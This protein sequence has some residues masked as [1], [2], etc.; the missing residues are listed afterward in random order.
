MITRE[1]AGAL[2]R[3]K[4]SDRKVAHVF[5]KHFKQDVEELIISQSAIRQAQIKHREAFAAEIKVAFKP[6]ILHW[7][8]KIMENAQVLE[9]SD[10]TAYPLL[11]LDKTL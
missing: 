11:S 7:D 8:G 9:Q 3:T 4:I 5:A 10:S 1:V 6:L 2:D